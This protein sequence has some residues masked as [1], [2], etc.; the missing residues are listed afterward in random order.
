MKWFQECFAMAD[1]VTLVIVDRSR[2]KRKGKARQMSRLAGEFCTRGALAKLKDFNLQGWDVY[3]SVNPT[4]A[5]S[6]R[7]VRDVRRL[8]V[9]LDTDGD[10]KLRALVGDARR[11]V[12]P[13]PA[14]IV[15]SSASR[16]HVLWH[17]EPAAWTAGGAVE[18]NRRLA[19]AYGGDPADVDVTRVFRV[20][21]F[22]N[23]KAGR[24]RALVAM[25][26]RER[27]DPEGAGRRWVE[28]SAFRSVGVRGGWS[29]EVVA[30]VESTAGRAEAERPRTARG[31]A[32]YI[33]GRRLAES[34]SE[35]DWQEVV[36]E[37]AG[38]R[39]PDLVIQ[40]LA[41]ARSDKGNPRDYA[42]RTVV[43]AC[44]S[45]GLQEPETEY[46]RRHPVAALVR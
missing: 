15:R 5:G 41:A 12:V 45:L 13:M 17:A 29:G 31:P 27:F 42:E 16:W 39:Q 7:S 25:V 4:V 26:P 38:G 34:Q 1:R 35:V 3:C 28:P 20:P 44:R 18:A 32:Q 22:R 46:G 36:D 19:H 11:G 23:C 40:D 9:E 10:E 30:A 2:G 43:K 6:S 33:G 21:G 24:E 37:L 14:V 8:Q